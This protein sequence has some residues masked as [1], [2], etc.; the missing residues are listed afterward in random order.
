MAKK[1]K[2]EPSWDKIGK[3][4]GKKMEKA[5]WSGCANWHKEC[6]GGFGRLL[7]ALGLLFALSA[8]GVLEGVPV[9]T[10][11]LMVIGFTLMKF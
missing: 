10:Q 3:S 8:V 4:I 9:W 1:R 7:F 2:K 6:G 11:I 5:D